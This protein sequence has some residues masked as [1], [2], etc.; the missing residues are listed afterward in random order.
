M[1]RKRPNGAAALKV[2]RDY[3]GRVLPLFSA[4]RGMVSPVQ[5]LDSIWN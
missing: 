4:R 2:V 3:M 5:P 1:P